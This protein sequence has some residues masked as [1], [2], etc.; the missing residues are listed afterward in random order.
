MAT[1]E[2]AAKSVGIPLL[3]SVKGEDKGD[4]SKRKGSRSQNF[5]GWRAGILFGITA[6][7]VVLLLNVLLTIISVR[8][9]AVVGGLATLQRGSCSQMRQASR[10]LHLM[11]NILSTALLAASNYGMQCL[12]AP[13]RQDIDKAHSKRRWLDIGVPSMRNLRSISGARVFL[14]SL[15]AISS[16]PLHLLYNSALISTLASQEYALYVG[17]PSLL[18]G[19]GIDWSKPIATFRSYGY[20][21][22]GRT[23]GNPPTLRLPRHQHLGTP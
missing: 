11:I 4:G 18:T 7:A 23:V 22:E 21:T 13:T 10:W 9:Y 5:E 6:T 14:W 15:L 17:S 1:E 16:I 12:S 3:S 20:N 19:D 8:K 2:A